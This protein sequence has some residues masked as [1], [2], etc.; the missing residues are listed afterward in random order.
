MTSTITLTSYKV[1]QKL[2]ADHC[3]DR[4]GME[5]DALHAILAMP[6]THHDAVFCLRAHFEGGRYVRDD[7]R[8]VP[9]CRE[10]LG[11]TTEYRP[12]IVKDR[13]RLSMHQ[14]RSTHDLSA[15]NLADRLMAQADAEY[16]NRLMKALHH[17]FRNT[18]LRRGS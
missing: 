6:Q 7:E 17:S 13:T 9:R 14:G 1:R 10:S 5:L 18:G 16:G 15:E 4:L 8:V 2:F 3:H 11:Q 12:G